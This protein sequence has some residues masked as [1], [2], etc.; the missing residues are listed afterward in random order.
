MDPFLIHTR[1]GRK[2]AIKLMRQALVAFSLLLE[3][4]HLV[5]GPV[6]PVVV[7]VSAAAISGP[8]PV[9]ISV[10]KSLSGSTLISTAAAECPQ[11]SRS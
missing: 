3:R 2:A 6:Q 11:C 8:I 4:M 5:T 10:D 1:S 7:T 9:P